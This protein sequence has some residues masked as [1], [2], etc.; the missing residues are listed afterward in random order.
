MFTKDQA[1]ALVRDRVRSLFSKKDW[2]VV[3]DE[4]I[5]AS[6]G[7]AFFYTL[8]EFVDDK[9]GPNLMGGGPVLFVKDTGG[10]VFCGSNKGASAWIADFE[11]GLLND[12]IVY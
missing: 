11:A 8:P 6:F 3:E 9:L 4:A 12:R 5:D 10:M 7:W 1:A 2:V